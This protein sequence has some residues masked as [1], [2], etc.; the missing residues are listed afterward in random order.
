MQMRARVAIRASWVR[1]EVA[2]WFRDPISEPIF[3][4]VQETND[5]S[6]EL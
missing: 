3:F 4:F 5:F 2:F 6:C 1:R